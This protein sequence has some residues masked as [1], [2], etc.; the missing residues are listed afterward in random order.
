VVV[1]PRVDLHPAS[2][3]FE[4]AAGRIRTRHAFSYGSHYDPTNTSFGLLIAHNDDVLAPGAGYDEHRHSAV[5][6]VSWVVE[7]ALRHEDDLGTNTVITP[8]VVQR[9]S[10]GSGVRHGEWNAASTP[11]RYLQMWIEPAV[12]GPPVY[13]TASFAG[14]GF[15]TLASGRGPAPLPLR[16]PAGF[17]VA[18]LDAGEDAALQAADFVH[19]SV[20][21]G[22]IQVAAGG[23][24]VA[25]DDGDTL[26]LTGAGS[27]VVRADRDAEV[28]AW[29]M[30]GSP[31]A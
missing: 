22:A 20:V 8:G 9:L 1:N 15:V 28:L 5:D 12:E 14:S 7:G 2:A 29:S 18:R 23:S 21:R 27:L 30:D 10:A 26:R 25:M 16:A 3:R 19:L 31:L 11:T 17:A 6:I 13:G 4:T 24:T